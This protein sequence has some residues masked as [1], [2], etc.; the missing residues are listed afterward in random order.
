MSFDDIALTGGEEQLLGGGVKKILCS[1]V[2]GEPKALPAFPIERYHHALDGNLRILSAVGDDHHL[3]QFH[4]ICLKIT[5]PCR[6]IDIAL[7]E[8]FKFLLPV[9]VSTLYRLTLTVLVQLLPHM[10]SHLLKSI[11]LMRHT[12]GKVIVE[13]LVVK[14]DLSG[15]LGAGTQHH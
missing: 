10:F 8:K 4:R 9:H 7:Q 5:T 11:Y 2:N 12:L 1:A 6:T 3:F 13:T 14:I 15:I